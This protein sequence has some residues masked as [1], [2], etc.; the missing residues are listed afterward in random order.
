MILKIAWRNI[1]RNPVRSW[2]L[3]VA[4]VMGM[5]AG[6]FSTTFMY[7]WMMQRLKAGIE[8]ET[9]HIQIHKPGFNMAEDIQSYFDGVNSL[10]QS[11]EKT[12]SVQSVSS[13]IVIS[14]MAATTEKAVGVQVLGINPYR[15][16]LVVDVAKKV[17]EGSWFRGVKRNPVVLGE[18]L[19]KKLHLKLGS[20][21]I[22]RFQDSHGEISGG[23]FRVTGIF[24]TN[25]TGYDETHLFVKDNDLQRLTLLPDDIAHEVVIR[26]IDPT[27][28]NK[29]KEKLVLLA[30]GLEVESWK[31]ISPELGYLTETMNAYMYVFILI[32]LFALGFGIVNTMLMAVMER[33][34]ELGMLIAVG[35]K[36]QQ[37]FLMIVYETLILS[38]FGGLM[39]ILLGIGT[40]QY[41]S[42]TG[43][44]LSVW[45]EG[46]SEMG[47]ASII[48]PMY[49]IQM[50]VSVVFMVMLTGILASLYPAYKALKLNPAEALQSI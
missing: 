33:F 30:K 22:L 6:V 41:T 35:M 18:K 47:Y 31:E 9:G 7:G 44:N 20:K 17:T 26:C 27:V 5:Y 25:N 48:Y 43:I 49:H 21:M 1:W 11:I 3:I 29:V 16:S 24:K 8:T 36:R 50:I 2:I 23:A 39:G 10:I 34:H 13:R 12:D 32:I 45:T 19:A 46:L 42:H 14:A 37:V 15:D 28:V 38:L 40:T 4:L